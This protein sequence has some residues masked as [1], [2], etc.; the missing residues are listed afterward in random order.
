M[1]LKCFSAALHTDA[2]LLQAPSLRLMFTAASSASRCPS[3]LRIRWGGCCGLEDHPRGP[4]ADQSKARTSKL[5][6]AAMLRCQTGSSLALKCF[7]EAFHTP[8]HFRHRPGIAA[9]RSFRATI[10]AAKADSRSLCFQC[11]RTAYSVT[12]ASAAP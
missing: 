10:P 1:A 6:A 2:L 8:R 5:A 12:D 7:G 9:M 4:S 3:R 11:D